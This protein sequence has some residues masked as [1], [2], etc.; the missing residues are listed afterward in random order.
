M[1]YLL[2]FIIFQFLHVA[3]LRFTIPCA[4][5]TST[6]LRVLLIKKITYRKN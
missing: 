3:Q 5:K 6:E 4:S 1:N 2:Q